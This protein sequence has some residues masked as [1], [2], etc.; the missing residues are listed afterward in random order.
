[1]ERIS[2]ER[3]KE[4]WQYVV[5]GSGLAL[6]VRVVWLRRER[7]WRL[8]TAGR[9]ELLCVVCPGDDVSDPECE[10]V[11]G[12]CEFNGLPLEAMEALSKYG[13]PHDPSTERPEAFWQA[14][15]RLTMGKPVVVPSRG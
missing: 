13:R 15:E 7:V 11:G 8:V 2:R 9:H 6:D 14:L 12:P 4:G 5:K 1:M 10:Y 3:H